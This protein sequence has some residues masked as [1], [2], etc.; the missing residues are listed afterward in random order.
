VSPLRL[1]AHVR[2]PS[3]DVRNF[4]RAQLVLQIEML[5]DV[6]L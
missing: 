2:E 3:L 6:T 1:G 4:E 5:R